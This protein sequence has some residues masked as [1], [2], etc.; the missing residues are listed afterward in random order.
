VRQ[1]NAHYL[2]GL[3]QLGLGEKKKPTPLSRRRWNCIPPMWARANNRDKVT[4]HLFTGPTECRSNNVSNE[5]EYNS[6]SGKPRE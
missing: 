5:S 1:A 2:I 6:H 3:G 4:G